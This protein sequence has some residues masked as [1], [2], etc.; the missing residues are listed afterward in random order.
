LKYRAEID[1]LRALAVVPVILFHAGFEL[2][3]GGYV[4]VD[5]FF[6]I[7]GY[8]ITTILI[9]DFDKKRFS[10][11]N[12]YERRARRILPALTFV[13]FVI[14]LFG[15]FLLNPIELSKLG[16][17]LLGV[18]TFTSNIVFWVGQ[19]YFDES[20]ELN[21][22]LHTWSLA[23][24][25]QFYIFF[26]VFLV[27]AWRFGKNTVF[28]AIVV[29][30]CM[31]LAL[32][33]WGWR[34]Q[35]GANFYLSPTRAWELLA[36]SIAAFIVNKRGVQGNNVASLIGLLAIIFSIF[37]YDEVTPFPSIYA[38]VPV[39]G[40]V[41][42][43]L[44]ADAETFAAR[45]L[46]TK[47]LVS[48]G[49][50]SYSAYLW[51]Q[52]LFAFTRTINKNVDISASQA[53]LLVAA[54]L[55]LAHLTWKYIETPF[56]SKSSF[57]KKEIGVLSAIAL[58]ILFGVGLMSRTATNNL[59]FSLASSLVDSDFI[60]F[61]NMDERKF[62]ASR[63]NLP[64]KPIETLVMGSSRIMQVN[65]TILKDRVLN[66]SVSGA[67]IE[68]D[69]A[70]IGEAVVKTRPSRVLIGADPWLLNRE[71]NQD[72]WKSVDYLYDYWLQVVV[73][74]TKLGQKEERFF[75]SAASSYPMKDNFF[76]ELYRKVNVSNFAIPIN[77]LPASVD[78]KLYDGSHVYNKTFISKS[79]GS[80]KND[81]GKSINYAMGS[82]TY[83]HAADYQLRALI[84]WLKS[85]QIEVHLVMSPYHP[86][87]YQM[88]SEDK[89][90]YKSIENSYIQIASDLGVNL[91]GSYDPAKVDC[92]ASEFY[93][94]MHPNGRCMEKVLAAIIK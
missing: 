61:A 41:L 1:G 60:Y 11:V 65:S 34:N 39:V 82:F 32:S 56:R 84:L 20:A 3:G 45:V 24:E 75:S 17:A 78:K 93:D 67:S 66:V 16:D 94:G 14:A 92:F 35:A 50:I 52:P 31:S 37:Y 18:A 80:I 10:L 76:K 42:L 12:F 33:E 59:E 47:P 89:V 81:F 85:K 40:V 57:S 63:L 87:L 83:D 19:G 25:E 53:L 77:G 55:V 8:L 71:D 54:T 43:V 21:P 28:W 44:F 49:L 58:S 86:D 7:S 46:S 15:W 74:E 29:F 62:I 6:V 9:D 90:M 64:I 23:V 30:S 2:F 22:L 51:H 27:V 91:V 5:V 38:L 13:S 26:P 69:I 79:K 70:F 36:G 88:I 4:G 68:D 73:G 48:L 72:R